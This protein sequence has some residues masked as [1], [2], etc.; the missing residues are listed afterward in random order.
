PSDRLRP[1][2]APPAS[3]QRRRSPP[4]RAHRRSVHSAPASTRRRRRV[5]P[6]QAVARA[7]AE[8]DAPASTQTCRPTPDADR[9]TVGRSRVGRPVEAVDRGQ[10][11]IEPALIHRGEE[12]LSRGA[13]TA[14]SPQ[15]GLC[16]LDREPSDQRGVGLLRTR[17]STYTLKRKPQ[18]G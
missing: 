7:P 4:D 1:P 17:D 3:D 5:Q 2:A 15:L 16:T 18:F 6:P 12:L 8:P 13:T 10:I 9:P 11:Q 14:T